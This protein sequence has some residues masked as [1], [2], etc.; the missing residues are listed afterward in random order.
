MIR[1]NP[2]APLVILLIAFASAS[3]Q[4]KE[5]VAKI[6]KS[7]PTGPAP[8]GMVWIPGGSFWMGSE[9]FD[10]AKLMNMLQ[11]ANKELQGLRI[12]HLHINS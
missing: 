12:V 6:N 7:D 11:T 1:Q 5:P 2:T 4:D 10:D 9:E 8:S 3:G